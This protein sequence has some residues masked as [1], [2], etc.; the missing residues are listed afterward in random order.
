[1]LV[2]HVWLVSVTSPTKRDRLFRTPTPAHVGTRRS[3]ALHAGAPDIRS[4]L[5]TL[6]RISNRRPPPEEEV[7]L[8]CQAVAEWARSVGWRQTAVQFAEA[9]AAIRPRDAHASFIAGRTN[10]AVGVAWRAEIYYLRAI[11]QAYQAQDLTTYARANL[12]LGNLYTDLDDLD[13]GARH[14][15]S[16]A[17]AALDRGEVWLAAQTFHDMMGLHFQLGDLRKAEEYGRRALLTYPLHNERHP[18]AVHDLAFLLTVQNHHEDAL[19]LLDLI[20]GIPLSYQDQVLVQGTLARA[21]AGLG[22]GSTYSV[23]EELVLRLSRDHDLHADVALVNLA[24]GARCLGD[25][26]RAHAHAEAGLQLARDRGHVYVASVAQQQLEDIENRTPCPAPASPMV[27]R[28]RDEHQR[29]LATLK[30]EMSSW[31]SRT[32]TR[33][34]A[35][36]GPHSLGPV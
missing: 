9:G 13:A 16:A 35:Q 26:L 33:K 18:I 8:A 12:G 5:R 21:A 11:R 32:W 15:N 3:D 29:L 30:T 31:R 36:S 17:S 27:G 1:M 6:M 2:R 22:Q 4:D 25:W 34:E 14:L 10:R 7:A 23:A 19:C 20:S 28:R 24:V